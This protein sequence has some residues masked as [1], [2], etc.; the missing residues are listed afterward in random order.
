M[1]SQELDSQEK[2][3]N[4]RDQ[5]KEG[6]GLAC[7]VAWYVLAR[8]KLNMNSPDD[9]AKALSSSP[10]LSRSPYSPPSSPAALPFLLRDESCHRMPS[11]P[12]WIP[13][14]WADPSLQIFLCWQSGLPGSEGALQHESQNQ[15]S[16]PLPPMELYGKTAHSIRP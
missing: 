3:Q 4:F 11:K 15:G 5:S 16:I 14:A 8:K 7:V 2:K 9:T 6:R 10:L 13:R 1:Y 12:M